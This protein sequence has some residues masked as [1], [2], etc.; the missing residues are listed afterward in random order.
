MP[1]STW[2]CWKDTA[3]ERPDVRLACPVCG[4][5]TGAAA[6]PAVPHK[7]ETFGFVNF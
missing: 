3:D 2:S 1:A 4:E 6:S 7:V 5:V